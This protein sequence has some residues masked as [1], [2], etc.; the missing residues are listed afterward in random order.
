MRTSLLLSALILACVPIS[1]Q[2]KKKTGAPSVEDSLKAMKVH[3]G[4]EVTFW[5]GE[6]GLINPTD[7][8]V[9]ERCR[10]WVVESMN[11]RGSKMRP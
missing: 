8:D 3:E 2:D 5:A 6:P 9:D 10:V 4:L 7:M 11:Y 1:A